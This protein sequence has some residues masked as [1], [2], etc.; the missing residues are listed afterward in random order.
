ME[1]HGAHQG[2]HLPTWP[3]VRAWC[4]K[5]ERVH[6]RVGSTDNFFSWWATWISLLLALILAL[7][8]ERTSSLGG[9]LGYLS[10]LPCYCVV[11]FGRLF[12]LTGALRMVEMYPLGHGSGTLCSH[13]LLDIQG[14]LQ[15]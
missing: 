1:K 8:L 5:N 13:A 12:F 14:E 7:A 15:G 3:R 11:G 10:C 9:V 2:G 6:L 4:G